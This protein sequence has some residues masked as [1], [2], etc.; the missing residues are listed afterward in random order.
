[1]G[2]QSDRRGARRVMLA[3]LTVFVSGATVAGLAPA[4]GWLLAGQVLLG[5]GAAAMTPAAL[6]LISHAH[7]IDRNFG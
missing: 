1:M 5:T 3:G 7:P 6:A 4:L 2:A